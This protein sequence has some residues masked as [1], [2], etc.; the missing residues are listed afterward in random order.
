M[1]NVLL[2]DTP[3][4]SLH[5]S[6]AD[7]HAWSNGQRVFVSSLIDLM[8][9]ERVAVRAAILDVGAVPVMF[10]YDVGGQDV[11][12]QQ[13]YLDGVRSSSIYIGLFGPVYGVPL[14]SGDSATEEEFLEAERQHLRLATFVQLDPAELFEGRQIRFV[15]GL[16]NKLTTG[17]WRT[18]EDLKVT[19]RN[20]R[21]ELAAEQM[22][23]WVKLGDVAIRATRIRADNN[24]IT[25]TASIRS[26]DIRAR[27]E[28]WRSQRQELAV[29]TPGRVAAGRVTSV[30]SDQ[31]S[32]AVTTYE[33]TVAVSNSAQSPW[34][35]TGLNVNGRH[36]SAD[37]LARTSLEDSLFGTSNSPTTS[38]HR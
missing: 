8:K 37:D 30:T 25:V 5:V 15:Q 28:N 10:E 9:E 21:A 35:R 4:K 36:Y 23:P 7:L 14:S 11:A 2:V 19:V 13:A 18:P 27:I 6:S 24:A 32:N 12:A 16:R 22:A 38:G 17:G 29:V 20:R 34:M 1:P 31:T 33:V 3:F 26:S